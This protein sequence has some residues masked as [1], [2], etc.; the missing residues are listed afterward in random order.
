MWLLGA[1]LALLTVGFLVSW[2]RWPGRLGRPAGPAADAAF[3]RHPAGRGLGTG[4]DGLVA[5]RPAGSRGPR[6]P[7]G[8]CGP[9]DDPEFLRELDRIIRGGPQAGEE[10]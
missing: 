6:G 8:P 5:A 3:R 7:V 1:F 2:S 9:D 10:G 4:P